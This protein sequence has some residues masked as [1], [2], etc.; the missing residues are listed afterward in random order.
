MRTNKE[1]HKPDIMQRVRDLGALRPKWDV[2]TKSLSSELREPHQRGG[3][4]KVRGAEGLEDTKI[5]VL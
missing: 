4:K 5:K 3:R 1:T 2:Y